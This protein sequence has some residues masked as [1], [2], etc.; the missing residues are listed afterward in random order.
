SGSL[1]LDADGSFTYDPDAG[2]N[3][4]DSFEYEAADDSSAADTASVTITV[5]PRNDPPVASADS[6]RTNRNQTLSVSAPGVLDNDSD[7]DGDSLRASLVSGGT[8]GTVTLEG[9]GSFEYTP[10]QDFAGADAFTYE[11]A[12]GRGGTDQAEVMIAVNARPTASDDSNQTIES[13]PVTTDVLA[14]DSDPDGR[15]NASTVQVQTNPS[16]GSA[17][18]NSDG[19]ITYT[20]DAGFTGTDSYAY[21]VEDDDGARSNEATVTI[22]VL[23][24]I[25]SVKRTPKVPDSGEPL[26]VK[27]TVSEAFT[28]T[29]RR[30]FYRK[31]GRQDFQSTGLEPTGQSA[32]E[33]TVP[34]SAVTKR[35]LQYYV[36]LSDGTTT[37]T[38]PPEVPQSVPVRTRRMRAGVTLAPDRYRMI[39][40]PVRLDT[41]RALAQLRDDFGRVDRSEWRLLRWSP[42]ADEYKEITTEE[43]ASRSGEGELVPGR[44]YWLITRSGQTREGRSTF[45]VGPGRS[46][47]AAPLPIELPPGCSQVANP[48]PYPVAWSEVEGSGSVMSPV[49][50]DP[51]TTDSLNFGV[52][53]LEPWTGYWVCNPGGS[54]VQISVP[55]QETGVGAAQ[56]GGR[57]Y[58][59]GKNPLF[60]DESMFDVRPTYALRLNARLKRAGAP[61]LR[62]VQN[63]VGV[64]EAGH[65]GVRTEDVAEPPPISDE[66]LRLVVVEETS[67]GRPMQLAG[68]LRPPSSKGQ[69]WDLK[70]SASGAGSKP[71]TVWGRLQVRGDVPQDFERHLLDRDTG[72]PIPVGENGTFTLRLTGKQPVRHLRLI[73]GT[74]RFAEAKSES[75]QP[76]RTGLRAVYPNPSRGA[77]SVDYHLKEAQRVEV[78]VYDLLGRT[79]KTLADGR[80]EAGYHT[81]RWNAAKVASGVYLVR[82]KTESMSA[83]QR[84]SVIH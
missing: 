54:A 76:E 7:P 28:P 68:S 59:S 12:D 4:T 79:I 50:Y 17:S 43:H 73:V 44:A 20:P 46:V 33:G 64:A 14:N 18:A 77:V 48:R 8:S 81:V 27:V 83:T 6:F 53:V 45:D 15:L 34:G 52:E 13:Q 51:T 57:G 11:A 3:G 62:D 65:S 32:Y 39:S 67:S 25:Q 71:H 55:P 82:L 26:T 29:E 35:G 30:L 56:E 10:D 42:Q 37:T 22:D 49:A 60:G 24:P 84:I 36:R 38:A 69:T 16:N 58:A 63:V 75:I 72:R 78:R 47:P 9:D 74:E 21:T 23:A 61:D 2:F 31:V 40:V 66:D 41:T 19:T 70:V 5:E 80:Q 1:T